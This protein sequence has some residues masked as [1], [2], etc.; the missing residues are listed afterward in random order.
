MQALIF[1]AKKDS[2]IL[3]TRLTIYMKELKTERKGLGVDFNSTG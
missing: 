3:K 1:L 2:G